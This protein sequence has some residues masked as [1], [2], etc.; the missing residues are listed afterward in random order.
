MPSQTVKSHFAIH[1]V[2]VLTGFTKYMLDYLTRDNIFAPSQGTQAHRGRRRRY[3]Y[4]DVVLLRALHAICAGKGKISHLRESLV[5]FRKRF[6]PITPGEKLESLLIVQ[7]DK[8]CSYRAGEGSLELVTGQ[9]ALSFVVDLSPVSHAVA[10]CVVIDPESH[11]VVGLTPEAARKAEAERQRI[12]GPIK[13]RR[14]LV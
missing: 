2:V 3:T 5:S 14:Q 13:K 9:M 10:K 4:N 8:L 6:G 7:G 11:K 1:E 12:W